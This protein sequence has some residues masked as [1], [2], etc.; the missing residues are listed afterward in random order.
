MIGIKTEE[1][2]EKILK[3]N[4]LVLQVLAEIAG[5]LRPGMTTRRLDEVAEEYIRDN[6]G[7]PG[8]LGYNGFP[9]T[10]CT[11]VNSEVVHGIPS[12]YAL[13]EGD[14]ISVDCGVILDGYYGDSA[15]TFPIGDIDPEK[16]KLLK[17]TRQA[18]FQGIG[19]SV[20]GKRLGDVGYA[21]QK[22]A[23]DAGF[24]VVREMVG[25]GLGR[26]LHEEPEVPNYG[27]RGTGHMLQKGMVFCI[28]PMINMGSR[29]I[30]QDSDGWTVRTVDNMPSA[31][32][33]LPVAVNGKE[34][35]VLGDF[36]DIENKLNNTK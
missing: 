8:F 12:D 11:S 27:K 13:K 23:E 6:R 34:P 17:V 14:I 20:E 35:I 2:F 30:K 16:E 5:M 3:S 31:H 28:E 29:N 1:E 9:N 4:G 32:F 33:E 22:H 25:H 18:L 15:Y 7:I 19:Q 21:V 10:L 24:S 26:K 36:S